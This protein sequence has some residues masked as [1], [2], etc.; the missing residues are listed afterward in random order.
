MMLPLEMTSPMVEF[1]ASRR[2]EAGV[3]S[4]LLEK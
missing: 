2:K 4:L 1:C 3:P